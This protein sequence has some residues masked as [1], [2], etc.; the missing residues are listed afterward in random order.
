[1]ARWR[2]GCLTG[3]LLFCPVALSEVIQLS[4]DNFEN[5][6]RRT[7]FLV[8]SYADS[9]QSACEPCLALTPE[10][11]AAAE[12][13]SSRNI[14]IST[15]DC[16]GDAGI[17]S[18]HD[19][20]SY[21][22]I[23]I[24][25]AHKRPARY[26]GKQRA[27]DITSHM[28]KQVLPLIS[29]IDAANIEEFKELD[30][31]LLVAYLDAEDKKNF[32]TFLQVAESPLHDSF[33]F[34]TTT[35]TE[36]LFQVEVKERP[37]IEF[38]N[39]VDEVIASGLPLAL[40]FAFTQS[41]RS[42]LANEL[43]SIAM[44]EKGSINFATVDAVKLPFLAEP[45]GLDGK[46]YPAFVVHDIENDE[47]FVFDQRKEI[48]RENIEKFLKGFWIGGEKDGA[49]AEE[50]TGEGDAYDELQDILVAR[51]LGSY[52]FE[53]SKFRLNLQCYSEVTSAGN[54]NNFRSCSALTGTSAV[55]ETCSQKELVSMS[56][57]NLNL[58]ISNQMMST[59][60]VRV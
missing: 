57:V 29:E 35:T 3:A 28:I 20:Q 43:K 38:F 10:L 26:R 22:T 24:F 46:R 16:D 25:Q 7:E 27:R 19:V 58:P 47:T 13:L 59:I 30:T 42:S 5:H 52:N 9:T 1:M 60:N 17:C 21:P 18:T 39:P 56:G 41:E 34:G 4:K 14:F 53:L 33:L 36:P 6:V 50:E 31:P 48:T 11:E 2:L 49:V 54:T 44:K 23:R 37:F 32:N 12:I 45:L 55:P 51:K 40:I 8:V 15:V